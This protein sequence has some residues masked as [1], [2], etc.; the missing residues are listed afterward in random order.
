MK[1]EEKL[2]KIARELQNK[3]AREWRARNRAKVKETNRRHWLKKAEEALKNG[4]K[5]E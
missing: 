3:Y 5:G 4:Y 1:K 2:E